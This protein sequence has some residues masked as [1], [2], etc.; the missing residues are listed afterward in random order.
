MEWRGLGRTVR[1][2]LQPSRE[3]ATVVTCTRVVEAEGKWA[4]SG[5]VTTK[6]LGA[7]NVGMREWEAA[8]MIPGIWTEEEDGW[9]K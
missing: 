9:M 8:R 4:T 5:D 7:L 6:N 3:E 2:S 1:Q